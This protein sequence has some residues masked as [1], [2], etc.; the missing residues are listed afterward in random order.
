MIYSKKPESYVAENLSDL[1]SG[2][3]PIKSKIFCME[4]NNSYIYIGGVDYRKDTP[5]EA[6]QKL[7]MLMGVI[8]NSGYTE[9]TYT[10]DKITN[11]SVYDDNLYTNKIYNIDYT[12]TGE[13]LTN[14]EI[15]RIEDSY[16]INKAITYDVNGNVTNIEII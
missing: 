4:D 13:D 8:D 9:L 6:S 5:S 16:V 10:G 14:I 2:A 12:Y 7:E 15:T 11:K 1:V 3:I